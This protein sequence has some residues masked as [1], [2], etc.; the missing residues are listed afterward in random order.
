MK[1]RL[2]H[3]EWQKHIEAQEKSGLTPEGVLRIGRAVCVEF[4]IT[5]GERE[6][7]VEKLWD[8]IFGD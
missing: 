4:S 1:A 2:S 8:E 6:E 3:E 7:G 5:E